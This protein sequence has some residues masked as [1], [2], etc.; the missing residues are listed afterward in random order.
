M[1]ITS[2]PNTGKPLPWPSVHTDG[3]EIVRYRYPTDFLYL[4]DGSLR[5]FPRMRAI[6]HWHVDWE[7]TR[8]LSGHMMYF[9]DGE[10]VRV[11][12]GETIFVNSKRLHY[13]FSDDRSACT[14]Y[15]ML[16]N[17]IKVN[18]P[19]QITE[20][21]ILPIMES[22]TMPFLILR[23]EAGGRDPVNS[24]LDAIRQQ[25]G[26]DTLALAALSGFFTLAQELYGRLSSAHGAEGDDAGPRNTQIETLRL[27]T[28]YIQRHYSQSPT[29]HDIAT[30]GPVGRSTCDA[31]FRRFLAQSPI[32]YTIGV[33]I[34]N[35][36][37]LL[38]STDL[39]V[40]A[41][42]RQ[43][44]FASTSYFIRTFDTIVGSTP[45]QYRKGKGT[46]TTI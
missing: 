35:A 46:T 19:T 14:F 8:I 18:A 6:C 31:I 30:A 11:N 45:A 38:R 17:P 33:K 12:E 22:S 25:K 37:T 43:T 3:S 44:G 7:F 36:M 29:L 41:V 21:F 10:V 26:E 13:G 20:R 42:A 34:S 4:E 5:D 32:Q 9:V 24:T 28:T 39:P 23:D 1:T 16:I 15:C 27:M 2:S 40:A